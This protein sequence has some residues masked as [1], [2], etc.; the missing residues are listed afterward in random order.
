[1]E[2]ELKAGSRRIAEAEE[3]DA[4]LDRLREARE[5][6]A[7]EEVARWPG[8]RGRSERP[9]DSVL[10]LL[11]GGLYDVPP[12]LRREYP[13]LVSRVQREVLEAVEDRG[14]GRT[15]AG[16]AVADLS[17]RLRRADD[18]IVGQVRRLTPTEFVTARR[19][20]RGATG[21]LRL[22]SDRRPTWVV[23]AR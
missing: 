8:L 11:D 7:A 17:V 23:R 16:D 21:T 15:P 6:L 12:V 14:A 19:Y 18:E 5:L 20:L 9:H 3:A 22:M 10:W 13:D 1:L 2:T 4:F